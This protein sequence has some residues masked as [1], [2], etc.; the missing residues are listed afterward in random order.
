MASY[1]PTMGAV[2]VGTA[3]WSYK[4]WDGVVYPPGLKRRQHPVEYLAR[5]V[6]C[7]EINSSF[8]GHIRPEVAKLW[9]RKAAAANPQFQ[10]TAKLNKAFT[11]SPIAVV[12]PTSSETIRANAE[13]EQLA[14]Q[15]L[16]V[17]AAEG[18]LGALLVQFPVSFKNTNENRDWV[19]AVIQK[20]KQY[21]LVVEVRHSSWNNEGIL[22]YFAEKG[23]AFCNI[24]QPKLGQSLHPT[25]HVTSTVGY[26]RLHG[27]NYREW[28][29]SDN[30]D[31]RYNYLYTK[32]E[33]EGWKERITRIAEKAEKTYA[34]ANNHFRG[35]AAVNAI[36]LKRML[37]QEAK[38]PD[39]LVKQYPELRE[40]A[41]V[42]AT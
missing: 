33:L 40:S 29:D 20:F 8:Y 32:D 3:G 39:V 41:E 22:R 23:V 5:F 14:K 19:E 25:E 36:Q 11:H 21:P 34:V 6:D 38:A 17:L 30:R 1:N 12:Q 28:F 31:D 4:D 7:I 2:L 16:D 27:R 15:G 9:C 13:D 10:F 18:K 35:Q 42:V 26:V 37:G 24:D